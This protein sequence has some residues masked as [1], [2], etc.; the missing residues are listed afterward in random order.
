MKS[1]TQTKHKQAVY[2]LLS[3]VLN[4]TQKSLILLAVVFF[5]A[6]TSTAQTLNFI[7]IK[8]PFNGVTQ[9]AVTM[10]DFDLDGDLDILITGN[11][12]GKAL[13]E[14]YEND[15]KGGYS[16][17][18]LSLTAFSQ[19]AVAIADVNGD[20]YPD[21]FIMGQT[22]LGKNPVNQLY[23]SDGKGGYGLAKT[24]F[25]GLREGTITLGDLDGDKN[26]DVLF[27]GTDGSN[28][29]T[30]LYMGDGKGGFSQVKQSMQ[31]VKN[32]SV[33]FADIDGDGDLDILIAGNDGKQSVVN[34]YSNDGFKSPVLSTTLLKSS[35]P[36]LDYCKVDFGDYNGDKYLDILIAGLD[37]STG[38]IVT[39]IFEN[40]GKGGFSQAKTKFNGVAVG[41]AKFIDIDLDGDLDVIISGKSTMSVITELYINDGKGGFSLLKTPFEAVAESDVAFGDING[42]KKLDVALIGGGSSGAVAKL[43]INGDCD[44]VPDK[45]TLDNIDVDCGT[46]SLLAPTATSNCYGSIKGTHNA[47]LPF[48][49]QGPVIVTWTYDDGNGKKI[50]QDQKVNVTSLSAPKPNVVKLPDV[51]AECEVTS[52]TEPTATS[53]CYGVI[54]GT[55]NV[56]LPLTSQ[57]TVKVT[58]TYDDNNG[59]KTTQEQTIIIKDISAPQPDVKE[60]DAITAQCQVS[61]IPAPTATDKCNG[62]IVGTTTTTFPITAQ[63][64]TL[65]TWTYDDGRGNISTQAQ[66]VIISDTIA[67]VADI[68]KLST[69]NAECE[70][71]SI[72]PPTA[73]DN[74][75]GKIIGTSNVQFPLTAQGTKIITWTYDDGNGNTSTQTQE[76]IIKDN[77]AP[78]LDV[79][80]L[81]D[82][83]AECQVKSL[84]TPTAS[85]NCAGTIYGVADV[86][87]PI[88][89]Q[90]TTIV[91]WTFNDG[92]GNIITQKQNVI[93]KDKTAPVPL[94]N[95]LDNVL[96]ECAVSSLE[97]PVAIDNCAKYINGTTNTT[98]PITA[99]GTT[100]VTWSFDDGN[101]NI[102][103]QTQKVIIQDKTAPTLNNPKLNSIVTECEVKSL[104][105][106]TAKDNCAGTITGTTTT[107]FPITAAGTTVVTWS[108]DDGNG[109]ITTQ[110]QVV[111]INPIVVSITQE[112]AM[113]TANTAGNYSYQW[114][115]CDK[116][117]T[118][119]DGATNYFYQATQIGNYAVKVTSKEGCSIVSNCV[120][121]GTLSVQQNALTH[122]TT[123]F[124]NPTTGEVTINTST[125]YDN[126]VIEVYSAYGQL[127]YKANFSGNNAVINLESKPTGVYFVRIN[128]TVVTQVIKM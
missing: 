73:T 123:I 21:I 6:Q 25:T 65:V 31:A 40:D 30:D 109:N 117:N 98:F 116:G 81:A 83:H 41:F 95:S 59:G 126:G 107:Q 8:N 57:G 58:W 68:A 75:E 60:L 87:F 42:D 51:V 38:S 39:Q 104:P 7:E 114:L 43:Y 71:K 102:S 93:V 32:S 108:F 50:T 62:P 127:V 124:P 45:I 90:G 9:G 15:G 121:V 69:I 4:H 112:G 1:I 3:K 122:Q 80:S 26:L 22:P 89:A 52:L 13:S 56:T 18:K 115:D 34:L 24:S 85:D 27:T 91:T 96:A 10:L 74:C 111:T 78:V 94:I 106:P 28:P 54:K 33:A 120:S 55:H 70:V 72:T 67:P 119:I 49:A 100:V 37:N 11:G 97:V 86:G 105:V 84:P 46:A 61:S 5:V 35:L 82:F 103:T 44:I 66:Y 48:T 20:K 53:N 14:L 128:N 36:V 29:V 16:L 2:Y 19:S 17:V 12:S 101:G 79:P 118:P 63:G 99:Q 76:V 64:A 92:N 77:T 110:T 125:N 47:K 113:L 23:L 88:T